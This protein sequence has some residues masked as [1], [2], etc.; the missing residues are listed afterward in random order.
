MNLFIILLKFDVQLMTDINNQSPSHHI[1]QIIFE[2]RSG[3][4]WF[5]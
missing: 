1:F 5:F 3:S 2:R 4:F